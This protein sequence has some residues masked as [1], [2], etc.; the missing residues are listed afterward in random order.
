MKL[1]ISKFIIILF[2]FKSKNLL[3]IVFP[4]LVSYSGGE[5]EEEDR[6]KTLI[7]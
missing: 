5:E 7:F 1:H 3:V 4:C 6:A 2:I